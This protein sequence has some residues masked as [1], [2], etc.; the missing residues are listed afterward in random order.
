L[1]EAVVAVTRNL[2]AC[3]GFDDGDWRAEAVGEDIMNRANAR[4][5]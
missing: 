2:N 1:P 5:K 3:R 4:E